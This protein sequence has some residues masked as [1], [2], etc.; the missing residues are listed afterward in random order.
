MKTRPE[1]AYH[2]R[3][4]I[5]RGRDRR[6]RDGYSA[7]GAGGGVLYPWLTRGECRSEAKIAGFKAVFYRNGKEE[8]R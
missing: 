8:M 3:G 1:R 4:P 2:Y 7:E 6:W 5:E